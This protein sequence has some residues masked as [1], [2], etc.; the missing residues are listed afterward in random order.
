MK[1][2]KELESMGIDVYMVTGDNEKTAIAVS[3]RVGIKNYKAEASPEEK[4]GFIKNLQQQGQ[5]VAMVGDGINDSYALAQSDISIAMGK[6]TD[7]AMDV[8]SITLISSDLLQIPKAIQLS[9]Q[10]VKVVRQNTGI[11]LFFNCNGFTR[12]HTFINIGIAGNYNAI[13]R[14]SLSGFY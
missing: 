1:A 12:N 9:R 11:F 5:K 4:A 14:N 3:K 13:H 7:I 8:A 2:V 10:T 6:G